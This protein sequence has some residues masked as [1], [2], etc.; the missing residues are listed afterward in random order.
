LALLSYYKKYRASNYQSAA[1]VS[2]TKDLTLLHTYL[3]KSEVYKKVKKSK[4]AGLNY[5][6]VI[7]LC[8]SITAV[9]G[10]FQPTNLINSLQFT[11]VKYVALHILKRTRDF[12]LCTKK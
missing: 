3:D 5:I 9:S 8:N 7:V 11:E 4:D 1:I 2:N 10:E 12:L 6:W